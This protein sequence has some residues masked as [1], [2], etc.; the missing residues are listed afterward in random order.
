MKFRYL[1]KELEQSETHT[2]KGYIYIPKKKSINTISKEFTGYV[3][4]VDEDEAKLI[5]K[6]AIKKFAPNCKLINIY[7]V[8]E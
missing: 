3:E 4:A 6:N 7:E 5:A 8:V 2:D 1:A